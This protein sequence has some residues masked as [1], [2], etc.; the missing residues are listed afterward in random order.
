MT[1]LTDI[2]SI[3]PSRAD[4]LRDAGYDSAEAVADADPS[5]LDELFGTASGDELV[6]NAQDATALGDTVPDDTDDDADDGDD[7]VADDDESVETFTLEPGFSDTQE[8]H[9]IAALVDQEISARRS[10]NT[11]RLEQ[12]QDA[13]ASVR[14]GEPYEMTLKQLSIAYTGINQLE[15]EYRGTRGLGQFVGGVRDIRN[16]FQN[17]RK[18]NW[19]DE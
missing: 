8:Y 13:I 11:D 17:A 18:E 19:P 15:S 3:G 2:D 10:N 1:E 5:N 9:L 16:V 4:D 14:T 12:T 7:E 6:S